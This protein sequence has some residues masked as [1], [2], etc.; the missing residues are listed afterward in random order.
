[1]QSGNIFTI[2]WTFLENNTKMFLKK[3]AVHE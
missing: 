3:I 2:K 1:M